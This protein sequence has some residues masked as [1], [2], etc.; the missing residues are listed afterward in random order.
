MSELKLLGIDTDTGQQIPLGTN[1]DSSADIR[2]LA[3]RLDGETVVVTADGHVCHND[4]LSTR[5]WVVMPPNGGN[6]AWDIYHPDIGD[7]G[8]TVD[9]PWNEKSISIINGGISND[10][11]TTGLHLTI[12]LY[13]TIGG[14]SRIYIPL[15]AGPV[16]RIVLQAGQSVEMSPHYSTIKNKWL[17][18]IT[19]ATVALSPT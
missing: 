18:Y 6:M 15:A 16:S 9:S 1:T 12:A 17:Y 5:R 7:Q 8:G 19:L 4:P 2:K 3:W 10:G 14:G 13:G 11:G